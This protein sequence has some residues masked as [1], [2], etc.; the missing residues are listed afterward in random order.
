M[1]TYSRAYSNSIPTKRKGK[2]KTT[3]SQMKVKGSGLKTT[4][5]ELKE[6][7]L[8]GNPLRNDL[9]QCLVYPP[10]LDEWI[11]VDDIATSLF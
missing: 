8:P 1:K 11:K 3:E 2:K 9:P 10:S 6:V 4:S 7:L 5:N